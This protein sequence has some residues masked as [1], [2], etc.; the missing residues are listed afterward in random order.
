MRCDVDEIGPIVV[1]HDLHAVRQ[2]AVIQRFDLLAD[3]FQRWQ[4]LL[5]APHQDDAL[6]DVRLLVL[7]HL[8]DRH[9]GADT[10][11]AELLQ[12][13]GRAILC[14]HRDVCNVVGLLEQANTAD[15]VALCA[16][17]EIVGADIGI[18]CC[19]GTHHLGDGYVESDQLVRVEVDMKFFG[20]AAEAHD[21]DDT[22]HLL[23]LPLEDPVLRDFQ[24]HQAAALS[25]KLI[26]IDFAHSGRRR[27]LRLNTRR[28]IDHLKP[29]Q[30]FLAIE[31]IVRFVLEIALD[32]GKAEQRNRAQ[33]I[34]SR[35][36]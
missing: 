23:E 12:I 26:A 6:D 21:I 1:R 3:P 35:H 15:V 29:V 18:A 34:E 4:R 27:K 22:G 30:D 33:V 25:D 17:F 31:V 5:A 19:D 11:F 36:F 10:D 24:V 9:L 28:Q 32:V 13:D 16:D 7:T 14:G 2:N 8:A 20:V